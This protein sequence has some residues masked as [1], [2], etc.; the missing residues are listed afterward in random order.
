MLRACLLP[1]MRM[2]VRLTDEEIRKLAKARA[3]FKVHAAV[4]V[5]VNVFLAA[6]WWITMGTAEV[7]SPIAYWPLWPHLG[8]GIGLSIHAFVVYGAA[9]DW[10]RKEEERLRKKYT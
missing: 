3:G 9:A 6:L 5:I 7:D 2:D 10:E 4:Y 1:L 8:W